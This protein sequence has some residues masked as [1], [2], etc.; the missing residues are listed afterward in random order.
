V[1]AEVREKIRKDLTVQEER[2]GIPVRRLL[3]WWGISRSTFY[4]WGLQVPTP[5]RRYNA[6]TVLPEEEQAVIEFRSRHREVGYRK[7]TWLMNDSDVVALSEPAVYKVLSKHNLLGPWSTKGGDAASEYQHKPARVHEHWHTDIAYVKVAGIFYFLIMMLDGYSRYVLDWELMSDMTSRSVE[8][9]L[10]RVREKYP[11]AN[12]KL[13]HDNGSAFVSR[14]FKALVSRLGLKSVHTRR[15]HPETNG[16]IERLN[17]TLRREALR[18]TPPASFLDAQQ[19]IGD[20][21]TVY[22]HQRLH[23]G[24]NFLR[25]VDMFLGRHKQILAQRKQRLSCARAARI[26]KN[27][28][29]KEAE[30]SKVLH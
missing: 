15:N 6:A 20:F 25:P 12:P 23:Q 2:T 13:I 17:G 18:V 30:L 5:S 14:D 26:I 4:G 3:S 27:K 29:L 28:Q 16:K 11:M 8:D 19:I 10:Q 24:I 21:V 9:F 22:N 7:L 1:A